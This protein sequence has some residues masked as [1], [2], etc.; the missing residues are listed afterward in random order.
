MK[1]LK[2]FLSI[3]LVL[4]VMSLEKRHN[5]LR[6][7]FDDE[8]NRFIVKK[9]NIQCEELNK[10]EMY[11][12]NQFWNPSPFRNVKS[13]QEMQAAIVN[14]G[15]NLLISD[16]KDLNIHDKFRKES[17][18]TYTVE[19]K[20][21]KGETIIKSKIEPKPEGFCFFLSNPYFCLNYH[22]PI[23]KLSMTITSDN[24]ESAF[25]KNRGKIT[26]EI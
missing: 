4:S 14:D 2:I 8:S 25:Y 1:L 18:T 11:E 20:N 17:N 6:R 16:I 24:P 9:G 3:A 26:F 19:V 15:N 12:V 21:Q 23:R 10:L 7:G 13:T 22:G 5:K